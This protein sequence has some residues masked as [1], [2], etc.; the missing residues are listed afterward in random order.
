M[1]KLNNFKTWTLLAAWLILGNG[2]GIAQIN[3]SSLPASLNDSIVGISIPQMDYLSEMNFRYVQQVSLKET[4]IRL[5]LERDSV[6]DKQSQIIKVLKQMDR[7]STAL[8]EQVKQN[9]VFYGNKLKGCENDLKKQKT[10]TVL[11]WVAGGVVSGIL[12][13]LIITK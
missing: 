1:K 4:F 11:A 7:E 9:N 6:V 12:T 13:G 2:S 5:Y 3:I 10:K 8:I